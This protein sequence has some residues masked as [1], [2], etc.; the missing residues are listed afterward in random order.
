MDHVDRPKEIK[1]I[2]KMVHLLDTLKIV[3]SVYL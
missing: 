3:S 1:E 2:C